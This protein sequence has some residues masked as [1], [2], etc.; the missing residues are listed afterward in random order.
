MEVYM[1]NLVNLDE[2]RTEMISEI[3][4]DINNHRL[5]ISERLNS[6]GKE[7]YPSILMKAAKSLNIEGFINLLTMDYFNSYEQRRKPTG[8]FITAKIPKN[9]NLTLCEG[10]FNRFYIR[11]VCRKA[12]S[13]GKQI[14]T[15]YRARKSANPRPESIA[16]E[17]KQFDAAKLLKDLQKNIGVDT[18]LG[19][20][21]GPNSGISVRL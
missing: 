8:D 20:P 5:Y 2:V 6:E 4:L 3:Q 17:N 11:A 18:A 19:I 9:A 16:V 7:R 21:P 15:A 12:I 1:F 13:L 14:V 10:E